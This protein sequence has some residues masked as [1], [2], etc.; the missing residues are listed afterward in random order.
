MFLLSLFGTSFTWFTSLA[1]NSIFTWTQL[2]Q[3][4]YEY[5]Y[6]RD[7]ILPLLN[8]N[9]MSLPLVTLGGLEIPGILALI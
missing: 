9:I 3:K 4:F 1:P 2:E 7:H 8:K 5:C 6:S